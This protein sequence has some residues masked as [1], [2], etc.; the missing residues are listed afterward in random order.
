MSAPARLGHGALIGRIFTNG[1]RAPQRYPDY[2][3]W[4]DIYAPK[5]SKVTDN[6][7]T[8]TIGNDAG[9]WGGV[10]F[11][12]CDVNG[13]QSDTPLRGTVTVEGHIADA[14]LG[15]N[16]GS[17][18]RADSSA[19]VSLITFVAS[20][21]PPAR[22]NPADPLTTIGNVGATLIRVNTAANLNIASPVNVT[23]TN[24]YTRLANFPVPV[25]TSPGTIL[26]GTTKA[27]Y[28][29]EA[30]ALVAAGAGTYA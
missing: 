22:P 21:P 3:C 29:P 15:L 9:V 28:K 7:Q 13:N 11:Y 1:S 5:R 23:M 25:G 24:N 30:D 16:L 4:T 18:S 19:S 17:T 27:F 8:I 12:P 26:N 14:L 2:N 6:W 10:D 20:V